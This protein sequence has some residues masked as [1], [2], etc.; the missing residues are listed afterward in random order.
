MDE[1]YELVSVDCVRQLLSINLR[2]I[3]VV[4]R[5]SSA[6][7]AGF[8]F[9][10]CEVRGRVVCLSCVLSSVPV[11][12]CRTVGLSVLLLDKERLC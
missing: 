9:L 6:A 10:L 2:S 4:A 12:G 1:L 8:A 5:Y 11:G 7:P 3:L